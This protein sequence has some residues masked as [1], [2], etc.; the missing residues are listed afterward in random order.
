MTMTVAEQYLLELL[1]RARLDPA[2]EAARYRVGLND[3]LAAGTINTTAKQVLAPNAA[4]ERAAVGHSL[5][6]LNNDVFSHTGINGTQPWDRAENAGYLRGYVG[7]NIALNSI[8]GS[9]TLASMIAVQHQAFMLSAVHRAQLMTERYR[10]VGL[11]QERG[12]F[13]QGGTFDV[14]IVTEVFG[15]RN[16]LVY[17][18]GVAYADRDRDQ[19]YSMG[20][21]TQGVSFSVGRAGAST[22]ATGGYGF[23]IQ[24]TEAALVTGQVGQRAFSLTV[25]MS[26]GNVKLDVVN[27]NLLLT[28][29]NVTL[30]SG[31]ADV[32]LLGV[33]ALDATGSRADNTL[34][35]N[36]ANNDL[37]GMLG[38][39][40]LLGGLGADRL[41]GDEGR[42][43]LYG[44]AGNDRLTGGT[45]WDTLSGG[46]GADD[47]VFGADFG[48]DVI[49]DFSLRAGDDLLIND[50]LWT[51]RLTA[52]QV[53][54]KFAS[55]VAGDVVFDFG[56]GEVIVL[57]GVTTLTGLARAI[58][59]F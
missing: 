27:G 21:G 23:G 13:T 18:T 47:F 3:G 8:T 28:S 54:A 14:S 31:I 37:R 34:T 6:M 20:E 29:G 16:D 48:R 36:K 24:K 33:D 25:D 12:D 50:S 19:F 53:V 52:A 46:D 43:G 22:S 42:D 7:E 9:S 57:G 59:I 51:G 56:G 39:D 15:D 17:L 32:R 10:E 58:E 26:A 35:G 11:G 44:G 45:Q 41:S 40:V 1:N 49:R 55:V 38:N 4:L 30:T 2:A 5:W